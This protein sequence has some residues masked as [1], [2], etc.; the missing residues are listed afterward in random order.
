MT[1]RPWLKV[2]RLLAETDLELADS[3][4]S[5]RRRDTRKLV[6]VPRRDLYDLSDSGLAV[7]DYD[8][9]CWKITQSGRD[10]L[11]GKEPVA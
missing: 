2:L 4:T 5:Y 9:Y 6:P 7:Y 10:A 8:K 3:P 11:K 1:A